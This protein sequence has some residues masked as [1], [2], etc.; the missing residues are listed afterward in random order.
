[1]HLV[2]AGFQQLSRDGKDFGVVRQSGKMQPG[3]GKVTDHPQVAC[4]FQQRQGLRFDIFP[5]G[6]LGRL[7]GIAGLPLGRAFGG[8]VQCREIGIELKVGTSWGICR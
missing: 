8:A 4:A 5:V 2:P 1:M 7:D 6:F 3:D